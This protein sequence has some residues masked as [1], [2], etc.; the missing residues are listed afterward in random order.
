M[1]KTLY[2]SKQGQPDF[3]P[4]RIELCD[5]FFSR[6]QGL[7]FRRSLAS[8]EGILLVQD[9]DS[10]IDS[11]IHMLFMRLDLAVVWINA[12]FEVVDI[13]HARPWRVAYT[14]KAPARYVLE[15]SAANL[16]HFNVGDRVKIDEAPTE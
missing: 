1:R 6:F 14:P 11:S 9:H 12:K 5:D 13:Q 4:V 7:M 2:L 10:K 8:D 15:M 3:P 16:Y